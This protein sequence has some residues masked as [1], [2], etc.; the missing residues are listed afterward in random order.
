MRIVKEIMRRK[1]RTQRLVCFVDVVCFLRMGSGCC[2]VEF[3]FVSD[4]DFEKL[5]LR[6]FFEDAIALLEVGGGGKYNGLKVG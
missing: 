3:V 2:G 4:R 1:R 5:S 6:F